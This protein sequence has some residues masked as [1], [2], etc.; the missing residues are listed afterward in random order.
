MQTQQANLHDFVHHYFHS[1]VSKSHCICNALPMPIDVI[2]VEGN[3]CFVNDACVAFYASSREKILAGSLTDFVLTEDYAKE[4]RAHLAW[5][6]KDHPFPVPY[7]GFK[8]SAAGVVSNVRVDWDYIM[9]GDKVLGFISVMTNLSQQIPD[10]TRYRANEAVI[11]AMIRTMLC[12]VMIIS[13]DGFILEVNP[14]SAQILSQPRNALLGKKFSSMLGPIAQNKETLWPHASWTPGM[15]LNEYRLKSAGQDAYLL[16]ESASAI[17]YR[18]IPALIVFVKDVTDERNRATELAYKK[19]HLEDGYRKSMLKEVISGMAHE[20]NQPLSAISNYVQGCIRRL[21]NEN[22][23]P[24]IIQTLQVVI[25]QTTRASDIIN[26]IK[27][28]GLKAGEEYSRIA[29]KALLASCAKMIEFDLIESS[30]T[31][32]DDIPLDLPDLYVC[33]IELEQ[34]FINILCNAI[35]AILARRRVQADA[36]SKI[37]VQ[38]K[39]LNTRVLVSISDTGEGMSDYT[40]MHIFDPF[41]T[42]KDDGMGIGLALCE[43]II[44]DHGGELRC[45][46]AEP[47]YQTTFTMTLPTC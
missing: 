35:Y 13:A 10:M 45:V 42:T 17:Q 25:R 5:V 23:D 44:A 27:S 12:G 26:H 6:T 38:A 22:I 41:Y 46:P 3:F 8:K 1:G 30:I 32:I 31:L 40:A 18:S 34:V 47:G 11:S 16:I 9:R 15:P 39:M 21:E 19:R 29:L 4:L 37:H 33:S 24:G 36:E 7:I 28:I 20:M 43:K 14:I 2:D